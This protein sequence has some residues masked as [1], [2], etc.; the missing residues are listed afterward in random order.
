[1]GRIGLDICR[2]KPDVLYAVHDNHN[3]RPGAQNANAT[4]NGE[5][6]RTDDAGATWR[7]V[8]PD[9]TDVSGKA[10]YSFNQINVDPN[11]F[12][13]QPKPVRREGA[14]GNYRLYG[15][16]IPTTPNEP[17]GLSICYHLRQ[18]ATQPVTITIADRAGNVVRRLQGTQKAG[19]SRVSSEGGFGGG[20]GA[21]GG[22]NQP[23]PPGEYTVTL[24]VGE[25]KLT[26]K[27]VVTPFGP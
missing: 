24:Q 4:I 18:D 19:I 8:N 5:V 13:V 12:S 20:R 27:A 11:N 26:Q 7:K 6:Y 15:D 16:G 3:L 22:G 2:T 9:G 23:M 25:L 14:Q 17:N 21:G 1:M 10:G